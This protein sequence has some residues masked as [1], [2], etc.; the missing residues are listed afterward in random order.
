MSPDSVLYKCVALLKSLHC[1]VSLKEFHNAL[2]AVYVRVNEDNTTKLRL[3]LLVQ[4]LPFLNLQRQRTIL[5]EALPFV[6][7]PIWALD[8]V[9][10]LVARLCEV[11]SLKQSVVEAI[12]EVRSEYV[13]AHLRIQ[14]LR[15]QTPDERDNSVSEILRALHVICRAAMFGQTKR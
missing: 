5:R 6:R 3:Q 8:E 9:M 10:D 15:A 7:Q 14:T 12:K 1:Y 4:L 13:R 11:P 2:D